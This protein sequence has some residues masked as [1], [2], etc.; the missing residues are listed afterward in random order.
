MTS[1]GFRLFQLELVRRDG[2]TPQPW[3]Y[4]KDGQQ[5]SRSAE[6]LRLLTA[7]CTVVERGLPLGPDARPLTDAERRTR[8]VFTIERIDALGPSIFLEI[9]YG[10]HRDEDVG[11]PIADDS[12]VAVDLTDIAPT[13]RYRI[14][15]F[16]PSTGTRGVLAV[17]AISRACPSKYLVRWARSWAQEHALTDPAQDSQDWHKVTARAAMDP[18]LLENYLQ[19]AEAQTIFLV[20]RHETASRRR[21]TERFR[22]EAAVLSNQ[23]ESVM[24]R[25][26][27]AI[28]AEAA[29][30][31]AD[32]QFASDLGE[33]LGHGIEELDIDD[34]WV[35][36]DIPA[37]GRQQI[38]PSRIPEIF[39]YP[40]DNERPSDQ[41]FRTE[42]KAAVLRIQR[43]IGATIDMSSW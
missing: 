11:L 27:D 35:V 43:S 38:S 30:E 39:V 24:T 5:F 21:D 36:V 16:P 10:R 33:I 42:V 37:V 20:Q 18:G 41:R 29:D 28:V 32:A 6:L 23:S 7:K 22:I 12:G 4:D 31:D 40:I 26:G 1:Y 13:R 14:G 8:P 34:G 9:R 19:Q 17:E 3:V 25:V 15:I 2:R